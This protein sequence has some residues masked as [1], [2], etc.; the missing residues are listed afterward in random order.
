MDETATDEVAEE[1]TSEMEDTDSTEQTEDTQD[2]QLDE[3]DT[4]EVAEETISKRK[5]L[6]LPSRPRILRMSSWMIP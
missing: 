1:T 4:G 2:E 6:T 5:I 3:T